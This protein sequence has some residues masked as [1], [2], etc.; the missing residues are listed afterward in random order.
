MAADTFTRTFTFD[1]DT[2][3][4]WQWTF[5][6]SPGPGGLLIE[7]LEITPH[8]KDGGAER[9]CQGHAKTIIALLKGRL[10]KSLDVAALR[11]AA[12]PRDLACGQ[13]LAHCIDQLLD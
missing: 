11:K 6:V 1:A 8:C 9:G 5:A 7:D 3:C 13:A 12:C 10:V 2:T 4:K